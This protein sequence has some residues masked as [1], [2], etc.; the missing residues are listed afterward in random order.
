MGR[1][2]TIYYKERRNKKT[3]IT[4]VD[5]Q[6]FKSDSWLQKGTMVSIQYLEP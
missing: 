2:S 4:E 3:Y 1:H 5:I 6:Q